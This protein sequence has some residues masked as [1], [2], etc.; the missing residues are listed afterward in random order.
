MLLSGTGFYKTIGNI[1]IFCL[2][3]CITTE[4]IGQKFFEKMSRINK[5]MEKCLNRQLDLEYSLYNELCRR[6]IKP[7]TCCGCTGE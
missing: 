7:T 5:K 1:F 6:E 3:K 2:K 4:K